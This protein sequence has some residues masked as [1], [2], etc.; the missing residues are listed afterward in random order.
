MNHHDDTCNDES[1]RPAELL[2]YSI[3]AL[4]REN[5]KEDETG[6][7]RPILTMPPV[8]LMGNSMYSPIVEL[9]QTPDLCQMPV[10]EY[11]EDD[12]AEEES[13]ISEDSY[14]EVEVSHCLMLTD[15]Y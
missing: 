12:V 10:I 11:P 5:Y 3:K 8:L 14:I 7:M 1:C 6:L 9:P 2:G 15:F 4:N 13:I